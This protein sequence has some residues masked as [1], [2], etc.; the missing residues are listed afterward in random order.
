M[1]INQ[2][3]DRTPFY[4]EKA[5]ITSSEVSRLNQSYREDSN[6]IF[7]T[8]EDE[9]IRYRI[10]GGD[11]DSDDGHLVL[12]GNNIYIADQKSIRNLRMISIG[13]DATVIITYYR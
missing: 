6:A 8:V 1:I 2:S 11:P 9:S 5:I 12:A 7:I 13:G 4:Y 10:E 3:I